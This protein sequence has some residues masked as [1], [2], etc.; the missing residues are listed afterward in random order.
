MSTK[1]INNRNQQK[2]WHKIDPKCCSNGPEN[3]PKIFVLGSKSNSKGS[4]SLS[5]CYFLLSKDLTD[6]ASC[7]KR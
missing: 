3:T 4:D 1:K 2:M 5:K 7:K 6:L